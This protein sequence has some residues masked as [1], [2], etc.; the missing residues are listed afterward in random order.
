[1]SIPRSTVTIAESGDRAQMTVKIAES[2]DRAQCTMRVAESGD[3]AQMTVKI[4]ESGDRAQMTVILD[5]YSPGGG[6]TAGEPLGL[7]LSLTK[8]ESGTQA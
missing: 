6:D 7:L 8:A 5:G 2:G 1:M 4:A 3:Q